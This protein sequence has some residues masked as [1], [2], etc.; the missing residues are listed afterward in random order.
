MKTTFHFVKSF[1]TL[2]FC[3]TFT[4][5]YASTGRFAIDE[6]NFGTAM[7]NPSQKNTQ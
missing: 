4:L 1:Q 5:N 7:E 6:L 3:F 2:F